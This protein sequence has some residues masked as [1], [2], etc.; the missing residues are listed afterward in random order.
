M[1]EVVPFKGIRYNSLIIK[2][3]NQVITPP[4]DVIKEKAQQIFYEKNPFN[5]IRLEYGLTFAD[6]DEKNNVYSRAKTDFTHWLE[7]GVII[8]DEQPSFY[9]YE[10]DF[11]LHEKR[12]T[13][14]GFFSCVKV[15]DFQKKVVLPHEQTMSKPKEDRLNLLRACEANFSPIFGLYPD[16]THGLENIFDNLEED[17]QINFQD[18]DGNQHRLWVI[19]DSCTIELIKEILKDKQIFIADGHHRYETALTYSKEM[20][21]AGKQGYDYVLMGLVN[22][23][24]PGLMV[25]PTHRLVKNI[26]GFNLEEFL[27]KSSADFHISEML[28]P[29]ENKK[30]AMVNFLATLEK[31]GIDNHAFGLYGGEGILYLLTLKDEEAM[32]KMNINYSR[33][34]KGLDVSV[35]QIM[36][37]EKHLHIQDAMRERESHLTYERDEISAIESVDNGSHQL[38]FFMNPTKVDELTAVAGGGERMPQKSTFFYPKLGTGL[39]INKLPID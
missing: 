19:Q 8:R 5:I 2:D 18:D 23:Y 33:D 21:L 14:R 36:I 15:E 24:N 39:V 7:Q 6:D 10:T 30:E 37:F 16:K 25:L 32:E 35:L 38:A 22:L 26:E 11:T 28:I 4:Y 17:P 1:A 3:L 31:S 12:V 9:L 13:R 29:S 34:W 20:E 27:Y